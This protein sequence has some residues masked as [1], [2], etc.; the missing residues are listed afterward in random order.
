MHC[1][2]LLDYV[3]G[4]YEAKTSDTLLKKLPQCV[5]Q[6]ILEYLAV[7]QLHTTCE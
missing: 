1:R 2:P 5:R 4:L 7:N 6:A 3:V